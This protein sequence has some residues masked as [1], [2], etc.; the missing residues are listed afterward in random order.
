MNKRIAAFDATLDRLDRV[1]DRQKRWPLLLFLLAFTLKL[2]YVLQSADALSVRVPVM[3]AKYY[4]DT[5]RDIV[6]GRLLRPDAYFMGPLYPYVLAVIYSILGQ[7]FTAARI[8]QMAGGACTV[9]LTFLIG[10]RVMRP[11]T[12][13]IGALLLCFYGTI[14]FYEGQLLMMWLGTLLNAATILLLLEARE[15]DG[16]GLYIA[17]GATL[18]LSALARANV[19]AFV[20][21][22]A[23]WIALVAPAR[24]RVKSGAFVATVL[25]L[26]LPAT[27]H[28]YVTSRDFV[29]VT[30]NA[31]VNF[32]I[33]NSSIATGYFYPPTEM[34]FVVDGTTR[35]LVERRLGRNLS[36]S[37]VS[38]YWFGEAF[39]EIRENPGREV[40]LLFKKLGMFFNAFEVPQIENYAAERKQYTMLR[41]LFV[42]FWVLGALGIM[43]ILL[44]LS[45]WRRNGLISGF[46]LVYALTI[47]AFFVTARYRVQVSPMLSL[48][49]A[50]ALVIAPRYMTSPR[51]GMAFGGSFLLILLLMHPTIFAWD[52]GELEFRQHIHDGRRLSTIGDKD[53]ALREIDA[54]IELLPDHAEGY[55]HRAIIYGEANDQFR[56]IED[57]TRALDRDPNLPSVHYDLAQALSR[58]NYLEKAAEEYQKAIALD[59]YMIKAYNNLGITLRE[60]GKYNDAAAA[61]SKVIDL[62][63][64]YR[65]GYGNLAAC[66]AEGGRTDEAIRVF[67]GAIERFP[68][69]ALLYKNLAMAYITQQEVGPAIEAMQ[70]YVAMMPEDEAARDVLDKLYI[71]AQAADST[72]TPPAD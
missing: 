59:P 1:L 40:K 65:K 20:P 45:D 19:L 8:V 31:G 16:I 22:A 23:A 13:L 25:V 6:A 43:G 63:P 2:I 64:N 9:A 39:K 11:S 52:P 10:K 44:S 34:D 26:L 14:T 50:H 36:P 51:R 29:P 69:Y 33:G 70:R 71:A 54:A 30:S 72:T 4:D 12:A 57:Y 60:M 56:A 28:N 53:A 42:N 38:D 7:D 15:R 61:F 47:V 35:T 68:D 46:I 37:E 62:D 5:A 55:L 21:V 48:F 67:Q 49:A 32:Y 27:I 17:A 3:D 58:V 66:L 18:G 41:V 24:R